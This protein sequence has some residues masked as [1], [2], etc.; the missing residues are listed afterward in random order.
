MKRSIYL[1][2]LAVLTCVCILV[3]LIVHT[4]W[5]LN[6]QSF[7]LS[8]DD[9]KISE[10]KKVSPFSNIQLEAGTM[11]VSI[12]EGD[13]YQIAYTTPKDRKP[14]YS[15]KN[16]TLTV[17]QDSHHFFSVLNFGFHASNKVIITVPKDTSLDNVDL[18][19]N[20]GDVLLDK[21]NTKAFSCSM[22]TGD[23]TVRDSITD[24]GDVAVDKKEYSHNFNYDTDG[25]YE[26]KS[27]SDVGDVNVSFYK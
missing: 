23:V 10:A 3:G 27:D 5:N 1:A 2:V 11:D 8:T 9:T 19:N 7:Q 6:E 20:V 13:D 14:E 26:I 21:I 18:T 25:I 15:V 17:K 4:G 12:K 22:D 16:N 24:V